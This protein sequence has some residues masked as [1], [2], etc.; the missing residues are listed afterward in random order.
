MDIQKKIK[1]H[2]FCLGLFSTAVLALLLPYIGAD[3][4]WTF[5]SRDS[6]GQSLHGKIVRE[7]LSSTLNAAN[8]ELVIR[9]LDEQAKDKNEGESRLFTGNSL[10]S[11]INFIDR[12][13]KKV[14]NYAADADVSP[15]SRYRCLKHF[16]ALL[17]ACQDFYSRSNYV[18][19]Q[20]DRM[21][22]KFGNAAFDPYSI[23]LADWN[24]LSNAFKE[25]GAS[26]YAPASQAKETADQGKAALATST[27]Y[28]T[29]RELAVRET[30]RQWEVLETLIKNRYHQKAI[31]ILAALKQASCP[32]KEPDDLDP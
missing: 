14:L 20:A 15:A 5:A 2:V 24:K 9:C 7:A 27:Y 23:E 8:L 12:E 3:A 17:F 26:A 1:P 18:E 13:Q 30:S 28:K 16:G 10:K 4:G 32:A 22:E 6:D 21:R 11:A 29:A 19:V 31:T 25:N